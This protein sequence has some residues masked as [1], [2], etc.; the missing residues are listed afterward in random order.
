LLES[1]MM[2][3]CMLLLAHVVPGTSKQVV[4]GVLVLEHWW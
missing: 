1:H 2:N 4:H 3:T